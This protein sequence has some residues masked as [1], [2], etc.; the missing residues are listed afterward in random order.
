VQPLS[1]ARRG[2]LSGGQSVARVGNPSFGAPP[3]DI[4]AALGGAAPAPSY[5][6]GDARFGNGQPAGT[7]GAGT[8]VAGERA[9][10]ISFEGGSANL[11]E[12]DRNR[13]RTV[14][15]LFRQRGGAVRVEGHASSRTRDMDPVRHQ[16]VN[17]DVSLNRANAV[18]REL[19]RNGVPAESVFVAALSDSQPIFYEV[20]P[21][22]DEGNQRVEIYFVN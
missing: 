20:M 6:P 5:G 21:A 15:E 2:P 19:I 11:S 3:A 9:A 12:A 8:G 10:I 13:L 18:A 14:A 17:F 22:G 16:M 1:P 4:A 7:V